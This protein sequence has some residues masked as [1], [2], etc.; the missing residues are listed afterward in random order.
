MIINHSEDGTVNII[1]WNNGIER[2]NLHS[3]AIVSINVVKKKIVLQLDPRHYLDKIHLDF[4]G[5][6]QV[7]KF[8]KI[9]PPI[10][11]PNHDFS[12]ESSDSDF[13]DSGREKTTHKA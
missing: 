5:E 4:F 7:K 6:D 9:L 12:D 3:S 11:R 10:S 8:I 13:N 1:L 2:L